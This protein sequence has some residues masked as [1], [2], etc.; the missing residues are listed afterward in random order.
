MPILRTQNYHLVEARFTK[1]VPYRSCP[2]PRP[3]GTA[4]DRTRPT[5]FQNSDRHDRA[6]PNRLSMGTGTTVHVSVVPGRAIFRACRS[7]RHESGTTGS[8]TDS[9][10]LGGSFD[11]LWGTFVSICLWGTSVSSCLW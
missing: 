1:F 9:G 2:F 10:C 3:L 7:C 5:K 4:H 11:C 6:R 8:I